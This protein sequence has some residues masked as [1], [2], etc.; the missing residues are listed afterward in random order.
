MRVPVI[1]L[2]MLLALCLCGFASCANNQVLL[3]AD[4]ALRAGRYEDGLGRLEEEAR[5]NR[6]D[7]EVRHTF[8]KK[9]EEITER[10][11]AE[12][13]NK[14]KRGELAEA[15]KGIERAT[16]LGAARDRLILANDDLR[17]LRQHAKLLDEASKALE[18]KRLDEARVL[19]EKALAEYP[20]SIEAQA[21]KRR[22]QDA[23]VAARGDSRKALAPTAP[24]TLNF[25][26]AAVQQVLDA[27]GASTGIN[28]LI[29]REVRSD[30]RTSVSLRGVSIETALDLIL[31]TN[32]LE[33]KV[34]NSNTVVIFPATPIKQREYQELELRGFYLNN[35][36]AKVIA[37][38][39]KQVLKLKEVIADEKLN[40]V[41]VRDTPDA[42]AV[43]ERFVAMQDLADPEVMLDVEV[44][45]VSRNRLLDLGIQWPNQL[46]LT[47]LNAVGAA[48]G[49]TL[50]DLRAVD[51]NRIGASL[52][53]VTLNARK[54]DGS[55][56]I[57]A[58]PRIRARSR[59]KAKILI[60]DRVP[61][62][63]TT[64]SQGV[65]AES[66]QYLEVGIK[67]E[68]EPTV[69]LQNEVG[70]KLNLEVSS[71]VRE[72]RSAA[73]AL[74]YQVGTRSAS[75]VLRLK[76][77]ETQILGGLLSDDERS[78]GNRV[79]ALGDIPIV[80]RLFGSQRDESTKTELLLAIT[81]RLVRTLDRP[82]EQQSRTWTGT[83]AQLRPNQLAFNDPPAGAPV[84]T[85]ATA[86]QPPAFSPVT[87]GAPQ[88]GVPNA[89]TSAP[90]VPSFTGDFKTAATQVEVQLVGAASAR[91]NEPFR[92]EVIAKP[93]GG[94]SAFPLQLSL[95]PDCIE[96]MDVARGNLLGPPN[97]ASFSSTLDVANKKLMIGF[98]RTGAPA[99]L[100][101]GS[102]VTLLLRLR[103]GK[104]MC[105]I[106]VA[107]A[108]PLAG[109]KRLE[110]V[111]LPKPLQVKVAR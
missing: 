59:E 100:S 15:E 90:T 38:N 73:G 51:S 88:T 70:L 25:R 62:I 82:T 46:T 30:L 11:L 57:L 91:L 109:D 65:V 10:V 31:L 80:G 102:L 79:P 19:T 2:P 36:D 105:D 76:D 66:I 7:P 60:G 72:I 85:A 12:A 77:G 87:V 111:T 58:N 44:L 14:A 42:V 97:E 99:A 23:P 45:E 95:D 61:V 39:L 32:Q 101:S 69:Y 86:L 74:A 33:K 47:P 18:A 21:L 94:L 71:L 49:L 84:P 40:A 110:P 78:S 35:A 96:I 17:R 103:P 64:T 52:G 1:R 8:I 53:A 43:A 29:D 9:R 27:L 104:A 98:V 4:E 16:K 67:L 106:S 63:T 3:D 81:P 92:V 6:F 22:L 55:G 50:R 89:P 41:F 26:D 5:T 68:V 75:T 107:G 48:T 108:T 34:L 37:A 83:E 13:L 28:F 24:V 56:N 20:A 54:T 93:N